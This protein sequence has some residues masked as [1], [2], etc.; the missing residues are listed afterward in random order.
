MRKYIF[1]K[2]SF[3]LLVIV[4]DINKQDTSFLDCKHK[5]MMKCK[6]P[7]D[8]FGVLLPI[9]FL[10]STSRINSKGLSLFSSWSY[11]NFLE[12]VWVPLTIS[13]KMKPR[14]KII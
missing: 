10:G 9:E 2:E 6:A 14:I 8:T 1:A 7:P 5:H 11:F 3:Y 4:I 13:V 12:T